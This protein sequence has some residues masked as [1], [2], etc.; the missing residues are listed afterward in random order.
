MLIG[1]TMRWFSALLLAVMLC[2]CDGTSLQPGDLAPTA[3]AS[4]TGAYYL[5]GPGDTLDIFVWREPE[6]STSVPV[7]P[8][9]RISTPLVE[10]MVA[11]GQTP[12]AL[13]REIETVL[14]EYIRSP[15]VSVIVRGFVGTFDEQIR[16]I[17]QAAEPQS[18][19]YRDRMTLL[20]V[21]IE[22][23][24]LTQFASG[25]RSRVIRNSGDETREIRVRLDNLI[26]E[27]DLGQNILMQ[28]GDVLIIPEAAF[29]GGTPRPG[30]TRGSCAA[31]GGHREH[32]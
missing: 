17:G 13:A 28:P 4:Q 15:Q 23:G 5:I 26:N 3:V 24:G 31:V 27:G 21:V 30:T 29:Y 9:G 12:T 8:D 14:S 22:V 1:W 16:V 7:R 19:V 32:R 10:D 25:N 18:I 11:L 20:D 2:A 6:L